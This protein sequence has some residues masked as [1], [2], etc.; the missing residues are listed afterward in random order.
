MSVGL[1]VVMPVYNEAPHLPAT[2]DALAEAI[3]RSDFDAELVLVDDG[4]TDR[5]AEV[6]QETVDERLRLR[7][8]S[9][10]NSGRFDARRAGLQAASADWV[11]FLDGR[12]RL[13]P[14]ALVFVFD[15]LRAGER[16]WNGHVDIDTHGNPYGAF[17]DVLVGLAWR[18]YLD[19]PRTTSF[20]SES[21]DRYPKG[22]T[23]FLAPRELLLEAVSAFRSYYL[24]RRFVSDD[25]ALIRWLAERERIHISPAFACR[26]APRP[27]LNGFLRQA[28]YRGSTFL[29]GHGRRESRFFL[30]A[31][32]FYPV[33][34]AIAFAAVRRPAI[35]P[36]LAATGALA[37]GAVAVA[38]KRT[39]FESIS[40]ALLAP[41]YALAHGVGMWRG[42]LM[43]VDK[44]ARA[45]AEA[46]TSADA[47]HERPA[48]SDARR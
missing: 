21:F 24:N 38:A 7:V 10:L 20:D 17:W 13:E 15:R 31:V 29:D 33:S 27:T 30:G 16:V 28:V 40:F 22:T 4:S 18:D 3:G 46:P 43:M 6:V 5:S 25:T 1:S 36:G 8:V 39:R 45:A 41:V 23:C 19:D 9:Q 47:H 35:V 14:D 26:Y 37:A 2:I 44:R 32:A 12:V 42:L 34:A 48:A 11:L